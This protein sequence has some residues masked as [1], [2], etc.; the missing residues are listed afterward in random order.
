M[1]T[2]FEYFNI[3]IKNSFLF[4]FLG[5]HAKNSLLV[6]AKETETGTLPKVNVNQS[7]CYKKSH[8]HQGLKMKNF[9]LP[10]VKWT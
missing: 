9:G 4:Q 3:I 2:L 6:V 8:L 1:K 10:S 7:V 5:N